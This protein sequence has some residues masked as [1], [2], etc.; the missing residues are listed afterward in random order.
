MKVTILAMFVAVAVGVGPALAQS[1]GSMKPGE[2]EYR[3][4]DGAVKFIQCVPEG[5]PPRPSGQWKPPVWF[6]DNKCSPADTRQK[7][8][9]QTMTM[10]CQATDG[11]R[12]S[13]RYTITQLRPEAYSARS[14]Y[15]EEGGPHGIKDTDET[16]MM[17]WRGP[18]RPGDRL[19]IPR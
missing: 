17:R 13:S 18:C 9:V 15:H 1:F 6:A 2:W 11:T 16:T 10:T 12:S 19:I 3:G 14:Q 7:G 4:S 8:A 5:P